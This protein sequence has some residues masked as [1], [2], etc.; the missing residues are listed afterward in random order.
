M[1]IRR[2]HGWDLEPREAVQLQRRLAGQVLAEGGPSS[3]R[4]VAAADVS[5]DRRHDLTV[6]AV[7]LFD[8]PS[9]ELQEERLAHGRIPFPYV[10]GLL[11][12]REAPLLLECFA[13][14]D[15]EPEVVLLDGHGLAHPRR[16]G[17]ASHV[18]LLLDLPTIGCAKSRLVGRHE[19]PGKERGDRVPLLEDSEVIGTVLTTRSGVKPV[20]VSVGHRISLSR[21]VEIVLECC[22][23]TKQPAP[24]HHVDRRVARRRRE[25][26]AAGWPPSGE[27]PDRARDPGGLR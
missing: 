20:Y 17:L 21:A 5:Y 4:R 12:F 10:P 24:S 15:G 14:L 9:L 23:G 11:S 25:L 26:V 18:G 13:A 2:L 8:F 27:G 7:A 16:L 1:R 3:I 6:A 22:R 19:T